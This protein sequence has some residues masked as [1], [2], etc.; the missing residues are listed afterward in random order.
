MSVNDGRIVRTPEESKP[1]KVV[2]EHEE[3]ADTE[4]PMETMKEGEA[5]IREQMPTPKKRDDSRDYTEN[6]A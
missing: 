6:V 5:F 3:G 4:H 2:L 1:Y